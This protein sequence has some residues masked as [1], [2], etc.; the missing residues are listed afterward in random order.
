MINNWTQAFGGKGG[1]SS[2]CY[3]PGYR[4][5]GVS[6]KSGALIDKIQFIFTND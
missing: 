4:L 5:I 3:F 1:N 6:G 2:T